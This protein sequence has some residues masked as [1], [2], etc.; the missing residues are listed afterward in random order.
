MQA[1]PEGE[2][3]GA[4]DRAE[5]RS[6]RREGRWG[7]QEPRGGHWASCH[8]HGDSGETLVSKSRLPTVGGEMRCSGVLLHIF[9]PC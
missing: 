6:G 2:R 7:R 8:L 3:S 9:T 4:L 1:K 5:S